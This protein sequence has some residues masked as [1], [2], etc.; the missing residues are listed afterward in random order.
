[1]SKTSK[2]R[3]IAIDDLSNVGHFYV[4]IAPQKAKM[5]NVTRG[6]FWLSFFKY[7]CPQITQDALT[8]HAKH[9]VPI[10]Y[11]NNKIEVTNRA[12]IHVKFLSIQEFEHFSNAICQIVNPVTTPSR[13][14]TKKI[15][16]KSKRRRATRRHA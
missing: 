9:L 3:K 4:E 15:G 6:E 12:A 1:M 11:G 16:G 13:G 10:L 5:I 14:K 8:E 7:F 2:T